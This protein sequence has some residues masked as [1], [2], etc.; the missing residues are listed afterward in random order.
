MKSEFVPFPAGHFSF[1]LDPPP[2]LMLFCCLLLGC[3]ISSFCYR[4]QEDDKFQTPFFILAITGASI[5]GLWMSVSPNL[6][7]LGLIPWALCF[8][9]VFSASVHWLVR[10]CSRRTKVFVCQ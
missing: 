4:R 2:A 3:S 6:I 9:M 1:I 10:R 7:M 5:F 8:V